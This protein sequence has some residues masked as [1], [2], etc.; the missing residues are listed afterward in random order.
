MV[1]VD[2]KAQCIAID[3]KCFFLGDELAAIEPSAM[4]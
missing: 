2:T 1:Y 3:E 4:G